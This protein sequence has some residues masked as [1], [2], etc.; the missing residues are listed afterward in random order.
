[1]K[2][3]F[4][5]YH[6]T[7]NDFI[8]I[9]NRNGKFQLTSR[10]ISRLCDRH[11]GIGADGLMFLSV[12]PG[13]DFGMK[14]FNSDGNESTMCGNGGRCI[15]AFAR[16]LGI[17]DQKVR[18]L[19][20]DGEHMAEI[21]E[22]K[23]N[24]THVR[25][26]MTDINKSQ[27]PDPKSQIVPSPASFVLR[28]SSFVINTGSPHLVIFVDNLATLDVVVEGRKLRND[29]Q[30]SPGGINVNFVQVLEDGCLFVRT[31]ERGVENETLSCGTGVT[32][33]ALTAPLPAPH[34]ASPQ[35]PTQQGRGETSHLSS[36]TSHTIKTLGGQLTVSFRH[37]GSSFT[38]IWLEGPAKFIFRGEVGYGTINNQI[39]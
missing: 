29:P 28:P 7:G 30:F 21:L 25:L 10:E 38:D 11:F 20:I 3:P 36:V 14:Y 4:H 23:E 16:Q 22:V 33:A 2:L 24:E 12:E 5:K 1:M 27:I 15:A 37:T 8:L 19:A 6:G 34:L 32:A 39:H 13:N 35:S 17:I 26:R 9:D 18:F 31:Y